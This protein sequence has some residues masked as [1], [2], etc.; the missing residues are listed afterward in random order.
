M[1]V[2]IINYGM[3][4]IGSVARALTLLDADAVVMESPGDFNR[5]ER[6]IL[7]GV[8]AFSAAMENLHKGGWVEAIDQHVRRG[9][10]PLLGICLGMQLL[11]DEGE[12]N[13]LTR[14]LG[15]VHGRVVPFSKNAVERVP[16]VGWNEVVAMGNATLLAGIPQG[17]D[18]YF[19]HSYIFSADD[20]ADVA[21]VSSYG[22]E[23]TAAIAN[24]NV[25]GTQFHPEK[26]SRAGA[27]LLK[28]FVG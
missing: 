15:L 13:G 18:F 8:G 28:N 27:K 26:S 4:N 9:G 11:A 2:G 10:M 23:F 16:H 24:G 20:P 3:G 12:E 19:V 7:P 14:G 1:N 5:V 17:T 6:V 25:S 21:A 22:G